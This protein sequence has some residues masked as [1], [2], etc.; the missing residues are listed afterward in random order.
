MLLF[1]IILAVG[2]FDLKRRPG[3]LASC[4]C[5]PGD[6]FERAYS[7]TAVVSFEFECRHC[8]DAGHCFAKHSRG[9]KLRWGIGAGFA[10]LAS[11]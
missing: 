3:M 4:C 1:S 5:D 10:G 8:A 11:P 7:W 2:A 9:A 6:F